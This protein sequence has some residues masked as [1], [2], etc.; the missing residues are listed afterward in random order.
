[1]RRMDELH[2]N[3]PFAGARMLHDMLRLEG[4][5]VDRR[6][7]GTLIAKMGVEAI[8]YRKRNPSKS[9]PEHRLYPYLLRDLISDRP[10]QV[11][12]TDLTYIPMRRGFV[13]LFAIVDWATRKVLAHRI[14][15][16]MTADFCIEAFNKAIAQYGTPE[17]FNTDQGSQ[18]T[19]PRFH[20][21][22]ERQSYQDQHGRQG[23]MGR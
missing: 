10:N 19:K 3:Y 1:M 23:S 7:V 2:L 20:A 9:H 14:S 4:I 11:W 18:F 17:I 21:D 16:S 6:H 5:V 12:A 8:Y 22:T 13:Y 15:I